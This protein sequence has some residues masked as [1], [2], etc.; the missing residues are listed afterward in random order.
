MDVPVERF[1][2]IVIQISPFCHWLRV[3]NCYLG[4]KKYFYAQ[5]VKKNHEAVN[6]PLSRV[7]FK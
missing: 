7:S 5:R 4:V 6:H 2:K 1:K 3:L